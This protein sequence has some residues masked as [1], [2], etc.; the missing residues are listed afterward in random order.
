M[1]R[2]ADTT[3][4]PETMRASELLVVCEVHSI[5]LTGRG[6]TRGVGHRPGPS[7]V[8]VGGGV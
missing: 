4:V 1:P 5:S 7:C 8:R 6:K 2:L 3:R